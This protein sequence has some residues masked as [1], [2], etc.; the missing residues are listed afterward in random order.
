MA[1]LV[2]RLQ[3]LGGVRHGDDHDGVLGQQFLR[4]RGGG[5]SAQRPAAGPTMTKKGVLMGRQGRA[6]LGGGFLEPAGRFQVAVGIAGIVVVVGKGIA[7]IQE[8][9]DRPRP[10]W[11]SRGPRRR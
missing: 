11:Q 2:R 4:G 1:E 7:V 3:R 9:A 5:A 8:E 6:S 10:G